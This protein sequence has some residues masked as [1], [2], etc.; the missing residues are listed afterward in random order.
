M[1]RRCKILLYISLAQVRV[2]TICQEQLEHFE[3][4]VLR[5]YAQRSIP[6]SIGFVHV[7]AASDPVENRTHTHEYTSAS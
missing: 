4:L 5:C 1:G 2:S 7:V 6:F 3:A